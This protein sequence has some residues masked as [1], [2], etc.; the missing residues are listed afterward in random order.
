MQP[1][2]WQNQHVSN[3]LE[4]HGAR[5]IGS[6]IG[7]FIPRFWWEICSV[8]NSRA[9][10]CNLRLI[11]WCWWCEIILTEAAATLSPQVLARSELCSLRHIQRKMSPGERFILAEGVNGTQARTGISI[12][13]TSCQCE[14]LHPLHFPAPLCF[15]DVERAEFYTFA[16]FHLK[17]GDFLNGC[18]LVHYKSNKIQHLEVISHFKL[19]F[20]AKFWW[21][22]KSNQA[23][24]IK[25]VYFL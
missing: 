25:S 12:S 7:M 20:S 8:K 21:Q 3:A 11:Y 13:L 17:K 18:K 4:Q 10:C 15:C 5:R 16:A 6:F 2:R 24:N 1:Q 19:M 23:V 9:S 14:T 22:I